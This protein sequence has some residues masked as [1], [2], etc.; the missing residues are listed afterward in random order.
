[1]VGWLVNNEVESMWKEAVIAEFEAI[2]S[3][4]P[5]GRGKLRKPHLE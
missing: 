4:L 2:S 1:M 3:Q 5:R